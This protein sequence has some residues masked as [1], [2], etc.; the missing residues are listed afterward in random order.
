[1]IETAE[2][3]ARAIRRVQPQYPEAWLNAWRD[4]LWNAPGNDAMPRVDVIKPAASYR[5]PLGKFLPGLH[6]VRLYPGNNQFDALA[7]LVHELAHAWAPHE[8]RHHGP[9]WRETFAALFEWLTGYE[10][11]LDQLPAQTRELRDRV[12]K[13][14]RMGDNLMSQVMD[15]SITLKLEELAP[16]IWHRL[17]SDGTPRAVE[18]RIGTRHHCFKVRT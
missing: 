18:S 10:F 9:K 14:D 5:G 15:A 1:M 13:G 12:G 3:P 2:Q 17:D 16:N 4:I 8:R 11:H 7:T 6:I